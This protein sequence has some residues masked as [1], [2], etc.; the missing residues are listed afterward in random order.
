MSQPTIFIETPKDS[1]NSTRELLSE[2]FMIFP[3]SKKWADGLEVKDSDIFIKIQEDIGPQFLIFTC[4]TSQFVFKII[5]YRSRASLGIDSTIKKEN[6]QLVLSHFTT[7]LGLRVAN[8]FMSAFPVNLES[9]QV[10]NFAV[11]KDFIFFR[12]YRFCINEKGPAFE[13]LG[14]HLTLRL[15]RVTDHE[16]ESKKV[17]SYQ[18]YVKNANLL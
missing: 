1:H 7:E 5:E 14:P 18:K 9:N 15:W 16:G 8:I 4:K 3:N 12:M 11:H 13:K 6:H 10:V 2:L 17:V